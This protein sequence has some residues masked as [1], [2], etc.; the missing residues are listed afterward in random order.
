MKNE[1]GKLSFGI[2]P[3]RGA[4]HPG[5]HHASQPISIRYSPICLRVDPT[6]TLGAVKVLFLWHNYQ[7]V[8][9]YGSQPRTIRYLTIRPRVD[10]T[11]HLLQSRSMFGIVG[12]GADLP[13]IQ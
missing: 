10:P 3:C 7:P 8:R 9:I 1:P 6:L 13:I 2:G 12:V 11:L 5:V 4:D